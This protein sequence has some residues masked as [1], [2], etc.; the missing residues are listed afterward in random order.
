MEY[1][2]IDNVDKDVSRI[3]QGLIMLS[4]ERL[5]EAFELLDGVY[6]AGINTFDGAYTYGRGRCNRAFGKWVAARGLRDEV[7][8]L[9]KGCHPDSERNR[10]TPADLAADLDE[11]LDRLAFDHIDMYALHRDD[12]SLPVA[13]IIDAFNEHVRSGRIRSFGASNWTHARIAEANRYARENGLTGFAFS[14]P[15]YSLAECHEEPWAGTVTI[16]GSTNAPAREWYEQTQMPLFCWSSLAGG[17][18][19][20]RFRP[21][22]LETFTTDLDKICVRCYARNDNFARLARARTLANEKGATVPQIALAYVL[23]GPLN[24]FPLMAAYTPQQ[25]SENVKAIEIELAE[26][27]LTWLDLRSDER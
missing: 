26:E 15:N 23:S 5:D 27:E 1:A 9:D 13:P 20:G 11:C 8:I 7:V 24:T 17:F 18:F 4:E 6:E 19:S 12:E 21:D 22:N 10:V 3:V 25:A 14:S 2:R 16:T